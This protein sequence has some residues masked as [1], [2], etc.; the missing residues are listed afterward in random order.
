M[1]KKKKN[2]K[3]HKCNFSIVKV[4]FSYGNLQK[5]FCSFCDERF[6]E[7]VDNFIAKTSIHKIRLIIQSTINE[8]Y[9]T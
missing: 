5:S 4:V 6:G 3:K 2:A 8:E 9:K 1:N 7:T